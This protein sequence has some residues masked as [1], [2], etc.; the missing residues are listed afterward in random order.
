MENYY[1]AMST[2]TIPDLQTLKMKKKIWAIFPVIV[3]ENPNFDD[4]PKDELG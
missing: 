1:L 4:H 2:I 3:D